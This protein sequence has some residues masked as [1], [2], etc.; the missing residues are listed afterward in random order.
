MGVW[1]RREPFARA[2]AAEFPK[3]EATHARQMRP[4]QTHHCEGPE[5]CGDAFK[6]EQCQRDGLDG[7]LSPSTVNLALTLST[8][9]RMIVNLN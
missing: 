7:G 8:N 2:G 5:A 4:R 6:A 1:L 3:L 9:L